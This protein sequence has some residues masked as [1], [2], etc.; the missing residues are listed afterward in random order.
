MVAVMLAVALDVDVV[1]LLA[2]ICA[3]TA[4]V[5]V[6][7]SLT[8]DCLCW[9]L[10]C[11]CFNNE[12]EGLLLIAVLCYCFG[13]RPYG[14]SSRCGDILIRWVRSR[15]LRC[16]HLGLARGGCVTCIGYIPC[17]LLYF[18][19]RFGGFVTYSMLRFGSRLVWFWVLLM[20]VLGYP[21]GF[22]GVSVGSGAR[23]PG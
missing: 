7:L 19:I 15:T 16:V 18:G 17:L 9:L 21:F 11:Y 6:L 22:D 14:C 3:D 20:T 12:D 2:T 8:C 1:V 5:A 4:V 10:V 23:S 13:L